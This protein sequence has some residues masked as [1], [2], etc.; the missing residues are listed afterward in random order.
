MLD[1]Y[2]LIKSE[3]FPVTGIAKPTSPQFGIY[4]VY[5]RKTHSSL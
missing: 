4:F 2:I 5:T 3:T 1:Y